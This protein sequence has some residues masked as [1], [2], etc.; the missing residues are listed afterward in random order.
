MIDP[1]SYYRFSINRIMMVKGI[2]VWNI[3][4]HHQYKAL[5]GHIVSV[6]SHIKGSHLSWHDKKG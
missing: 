5:N 2:V 3:F 4:F 6:E 1:L